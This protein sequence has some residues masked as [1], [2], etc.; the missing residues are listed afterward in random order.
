VFNDLSG[1]R[2]TNDVAGIENSYQ[3][4]SVGVISPAFRRGRF[5]VNSITNAASM[6][7]TATE[8]FK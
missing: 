6:V 5:L 8:K 3:I 7:H 4:S 1:R 2:A